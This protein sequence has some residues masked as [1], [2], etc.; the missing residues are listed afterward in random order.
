MLVL[1]RKMNQGMSERLVQA[2]ESRGWQESAHQ[3]LQRAFDT[4]SEQ[5]IEL[6]EAY[7]WST[8]AHSEI[9]RAFDELKVANGA[10]TRFLATVF[11]ELKTPLTSI[12]AFA[13]ILNKNRAGN[14]KARELKQLDV[15]RRNVR[16]LNLLINDLLDL[17]RIDAGTLVL[18]P[19][20]LPVSE[21]LNDMSA[22]FE[23]ILNRRNQF[24]EVEDGTSGQ[25]VKGDRDRLEQMVT[26]LVT[27]ASKFSPEGAAAGL[28]ANASGD[29]L[30]LTV[31]DSRVGI[32]E[33]SVGQIFD[34]FYRVDNEETR[35]V[36]GTGA[37]LYITSSIVRFHGGNL[38]V[39]STYGQGMTFRAVVPGVMDGPSVEHLQREATRLETID[40]H[41]SRLEEEPREAA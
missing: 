11:H 30:E 19:G 40:E 28:G 26:N 3:E 5:K 17:T 34:A 37:G 20:E 27:N 41:K 22:M 21:L 12:S 39:D 38:T 10:K 35:G 7:R 24:L 9:Q 18:E 13:D 31:T 23:P 32:P 25:W 16:R 14:L 8:V 36:T 1:E 4:L 15:I 29:Q 6:E 2:S 33:E